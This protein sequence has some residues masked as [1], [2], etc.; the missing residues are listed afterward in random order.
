MND[1]DSLCQVGWG[2]TQADA[3]FGG[4]DD[5]GTKARTVDLIA[6]VRTVMRSMALDHEGLERQ[7]LLTKS[8][9]VPLIAINTII[10]LYEL[11][12]G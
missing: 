9:A 3:G 10:I 6:S 5:S 1:T 11:V 12:L 4:R 7:T 8:N 2:R